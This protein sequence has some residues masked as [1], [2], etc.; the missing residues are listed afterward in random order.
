[1]SLKT[2]QRSRIPET[3]GILFSALAVYYSVNPQAILGRQG[4]KIIIFIRL[5]YR[6]ETEAERLNH[7]P[8]LALAGLELQRAHHTHPSTCGSR[9]S[10]SLGKGEEGATRVSE[11]FE[12]AAQ[13]IHPWLC[14]QMSSGP[15]PF[16]LDFS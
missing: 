14:L 15:A 5:L 8:T 16:Q 13:W 9:A 6:W 1:M 3:L 7:F 11:G 10:R 2:H 12:G 4:H